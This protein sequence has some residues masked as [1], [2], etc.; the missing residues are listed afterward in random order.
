MADAT[1][2]NSLGLRSGHFA[3]ATLQDRKRPYALPH[4]KTRLVDANGLMTPE[5][6]RFFEWL[7]QQKLGG[8]TATPVPDLQVT[9]QTSQAVV[10]TQQYNVVALAQQAV[11]NAQAL[12]AAVQVARNNG[13]AGADQVPP[14][15][16]A[17]NLKTYTT[18]MVP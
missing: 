15:V 16:P 10:E 13:L 7:Y 17:P 3:S 6:W 4:P 5:W 1:G 14:V 8:P 9:V 18:G 2:G 12:E 11:A